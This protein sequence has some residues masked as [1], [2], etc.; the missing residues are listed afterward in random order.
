MLIPLP[1]MKT[2]S[3]QVIRTTERLYLGQVDER[4]ES[5]ARC[6]ALA[7]FGVDEDERSGIERGG[8][9]PLGIQPSDQFEVSP[10]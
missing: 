10:F 8:E 4:D 6:A 5:M 3:V 7:R 9:D 1:S 2:W